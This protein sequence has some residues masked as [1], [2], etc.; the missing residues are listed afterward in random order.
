MC[1]VDAD[2]L[3][4]GRYQLGRQI[5][6]GGIGQ[7]WAAHDTVLGREVAIK[8]Q[9][10]DPDLD[11]P[12]FE[13]FLR[14]AR[15]A[16]ALQHPNV[17]TIFDSGTDEDTAFL[18]M[19]LLPGPTLTGYL[20]QHGPLPEQAAVALA[21]QIASG[22][23]AAHGAGV[24]H[25]DI[26]PANLMFDARGTLK[27]VDFGI[28]RLTQTVTPQ[29]TVMNGIIGSPPYLSPE[30]IDGRP[31]DE[32]SDLY[33]LGAVLMVMLTGR[34]PFGGTHPLALLQQHLHAEPPQVRDRRPDIDPALNA[35][36]AQLLSK[37]P[38]DRPQSAQEVLN[39]LTGS[40]FELPPP[41]APVSTTVPTRLTARPSPP[42][43]AR[44]TRSA[45]RPRQR[46]LLGAG[47]LAGAAAMAVVA[48][49]VLAM[50]S[51]GGAPT[52]TLV[53]PSPMALLP[54]AAITSGSDASPSAS[55]PTAATTTR[56]APSSS[57]STPTA[58]PT[59]EAKPS[60]KA[61]TSAPRTADTGSGEPNLQPALSDLR[62]AVRAVSSSGQIGTTDAAGLDRR[63][64]GLALQLEKKRGAAAIKK[65][66]EFDNYVAG[67]MRKGQLPLDDERRIATALSEVRELVADA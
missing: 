32:R 35:L 15:S 52:A 22:L 28:A 53:A 27:I 37:S 19:E 47:F 46:A 29:L 42:A 4:V 39:R 2:N 16:A 14:E 54:T 6:A 48:A 45:G 66:D 36:V 25:R 67:L 60:P 63:V 13:R 9:Q 43:K 26:K 64:N 56:A 18:V 23:A 62:A 38:L 12:A 59:P 55:T 5:G 58:A 31:V 33:S 21:A 10:I 41:T 51:R 49:V 57:A 24:V 17:V 11:G 40:T 61:S 30:G 44:R 3:L 34:G 7:V 8:V 20:A 50:A 65:V 1:A